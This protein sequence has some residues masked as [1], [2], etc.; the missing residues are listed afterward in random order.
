MKICNC[1]YLM[2]DALPY[3]SGVVV[4]MCGPISNQVWAIL[5]KLT[6]FL[7]QRSSVLPICYSSVV[8]DVV[9]RPEWNVEMRMNV[10]K[11]RLDI[12]INSTAF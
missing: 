10:G 11:N 12:N 5:M 6:E 9:I 8:V 4:S 2:I 7:V 3:L 1:K